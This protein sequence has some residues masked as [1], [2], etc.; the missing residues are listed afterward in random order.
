M[1]IRLVRLPVYPFHVDEFLRLFN[2]SKQ[3]I[4]NFSGCNHLELWNDTKEK[5]IL[6]TYS[7]WDSEKAL[8]NYLQSE[9]FKTTWQQVKPLFNDKPEAWSFIKV[10][11][12][13]GVNK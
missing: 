8:E 6:Y 7:L 4:R 3:E 9:L 12:V 2:S 10:L 5:N 13:E 11:S 1:L